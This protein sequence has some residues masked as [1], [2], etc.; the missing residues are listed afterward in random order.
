MRVILSAWSVARVSSA[1]SAPIWSSFLIAAMVAT[2]LQIVAAATAVRIERLFQRGITAG[3][4]TSPL[5][6]CPDSNVTRREMA[7]FL[8]RNFP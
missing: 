8:I 4:G 5:R 3:C 1:K 7:V 2:L 6:Y